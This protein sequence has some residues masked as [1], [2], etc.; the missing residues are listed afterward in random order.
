M[1]VVYRYPQLPLQSGAGTAVTA[2]ALTSGLVGMPYPQLPPVEVAGSRLI[3][4]ANGELTSTSATPT[5]ILGFYMTASGGGLGQAIGSKI[6]LAASAALPISATA[7]A[8]PFQMYYS[9]TIR[10]L[11]P[12]TGVIHGQGYVTSWFNIGLSGDGTTNP[13]PITQALRTVSTLNTS[14]TNEIDLGIT[15][16][17][18]TGTPSVTITDMWVELSG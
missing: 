1:A 7:T 15:L 11:L 16:S 2:A 12:G 10:T 14:Q 18:T 8:W 13:I 5:V 17:S 6:V 3:I 9:G 4:E